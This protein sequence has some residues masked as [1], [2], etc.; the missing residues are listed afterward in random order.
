MITVRP[1]GKTTLEIESRIPIDQRR[2]RRFVL[3]AYFFFPQSLGIDGEVYDSADFFEDTRSR[4]R[5]TASCIPLPRLIE[6]DCAVSPLTRIRKEITRAALPNAIDGQRI[7]Y[8]LRS[9][10]NLYEAETEATMDIISS[11]AL[12]GSAGQ[13][14]DRTRRLVKEIKAFLAAWRKLQDLFWEPSV[15]IICGRPSPGPTS[16]SASS[17]SASCTASPM[18]RTTKRSAF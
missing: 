17:L 6:E 7:L 14:R 15:R 18:R 10:I 12:T 11:I 9:L 2:R 3:E 13:A 5:L 16:P 4:T 1:H 8:E